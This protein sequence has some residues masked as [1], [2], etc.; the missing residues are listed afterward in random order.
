MSQ[1]STASETGGQT[2]N[3]KFL[4]SLLFIN[5]IYQRSTRIGLK[6]RCEYHIL[7]LFRRIDVVNLMTIVTLAISLAAQP[8]N[9]RFMVVNASATLVYLRQ[10]ERINFAGGSLAAFV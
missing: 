3:L 10:L 1:L 6:M 2:L 5:S 9:L 4:M 8:Q 7:S